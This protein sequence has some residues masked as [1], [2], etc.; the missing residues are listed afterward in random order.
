[1]TTMPVST[2]RR[3]R[4][5]RPSGAISTRAEVERTL[6]QGTCLSE[7][8]ASALHGIYATRLTSYAARLG[9]ADPEAMANQ[10]L[11][12]AFRAHGR[13]PI[14]DEP[15]FRAYAYR[16]V[17]SHTLNEAR[18]KAPV[19]V[20]PDQVVNL[21][22][23][24]I[25]EAEGQA[26]I[27]RLWL[28]EILDQL[29]DDQAAVLQMRLVEGLSA[30]EVGR[31]L[32]RAPNAVYQLQHRAQNR[33][34]RLALAAALAVVA[35]AGVLA[36]VRGQSDRVTIEPS[37]ADRSPST[38][39]SVPA[40]PEAGPSKTVVVE[41]PPVG[42]DG[43]VSPDSA[44][45]ADEPI[46]EGQPGADGKVGPS[47]LGDTPSTAG[48]D[49]DRLVT[50][51]SVAQPAEQPGSGPVESTT[52][53]IVGGAK[54][55]QPS[56]PTATEVNRSATPPNMCRVTDDGGVVLLELFDLSLADISGEDF[57]EPISFTVIT[58]NEDGEVREVNSASAATGWTG[59]SKPLSA[60]PSS[61]ES[62]W[63]IDVGRSGTSVT[64]IGL[65][66]EAG[67]SPI[68]PCGKLIIGI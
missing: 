15:A 29:T 59:G 61:G 32:G 35:A 47:P 49:D 66:L 22:P 28:N 43:A 17:K 37:P 1:M 68:N 9:A 62:R 38:T 8:D 64:E 27:E 25:A 6:R 58:T 16:A 20:A 63:A 46:S 44:D 67:E 36:V 2:V 21:D 53:P 3:R 14:L 48:N 7:D 33:L 5:Q 51:T 18:R 52:I 19:P 65:V 31:R 60:S 26:V 10:A 56:G 42:G 55:L 13:K 45:G 54:G 40:E 41:V 24:P 57:V 39:T 11:F 30:E 4:H 34:R 50:S 12:D 23:C